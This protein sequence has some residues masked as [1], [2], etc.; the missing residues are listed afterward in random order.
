VF[1]SLICA[2]LVGLSLGLGGATICD[3]LIARAMVR[4]GPVP[5]D[6]LTD[7]SWVIWLG[8]AILTAS[9]L[10]LFAM[11]PTTYLDSSGFVAKMIVVGVLILNG[12]FL[13]TRLSRLRL[14]MTTLLFG[15]ISTVSWFGSMAIA[16]FRNQVHLNVLDYM[17]T[18]L[19]AIVLVWRFNCR[20]YEH[21]IARCRRPVGHKNGE[22]AQVHSAEVLTARD[23]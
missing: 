2:H 17:G 13:H 20:L 7:L 10:M 15:A 3:L 21:F 23:R 22:C 4:G 6:L 18:Y 9:G 19:V 5:T 1:T 12:L 14:S 8:V 11:K 16:M